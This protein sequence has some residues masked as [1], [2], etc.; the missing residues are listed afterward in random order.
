[1]VQ[2]QPTAEMEKQVKHPASNKDVAYFS[3]Y[4]INLTLTYP[5]SLTKILSIEMASR[6][7]LEGVK[8]G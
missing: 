5:K 8:N 6:L 1:M 2:S 3:E 7:I 4:R